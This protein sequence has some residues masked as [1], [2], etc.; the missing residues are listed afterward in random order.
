MVNKK[1]WLRLL[2]STLASILVLGVVFFLSNSEVSKNDERDFSSIVYPL[3]DKIAENASIREKVIKEEITNN[4]LLILNKEVKSS[5]DKE[6]LSF[7]FKVCS[8][9][10]LANCNLDK[11]YLQSKS[12][13]S[14]ERII[15]AVPSE[16]DPKL[17]RLYVWIK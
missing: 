9:Q 8:P 7:Q 17:I 16:V 1:A 13:Y 3:L 11:T 14:F 10:S 15:N 5:L 12:I 2:E 6:G 4:N